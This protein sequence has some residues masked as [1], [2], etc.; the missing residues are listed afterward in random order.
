M[1]SSV[2]GIEWF[3]GRSLAL[4]V[5]LSLCASLILVLL[6]SALAIC[7]CTVRRGSLMIIFN[8]TTKK[9]WKTVKKKGK[10]VLDSP[11]AFLLLLLSSMA[12]AVLAEHI[13][14]VQLLRIQKL[15]DLNSITAAA[16]PVWYVHERLRDLVQVDDRRQVKTPH[17]PPSP[18]PWF[19]NLAVGFETSVRGSQAKHQ[20]ALLLCRFLL[21]ALP[22]PSCK[23]PE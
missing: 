18:F 14:L 9:E 23:T 4:S 22:I 2:V 17:N 15:N 8:T 20:S 21:V 1:S 11:V 12:A 3:V 7:L 19:P 13:S 10:S 6:I 16:A 5:M